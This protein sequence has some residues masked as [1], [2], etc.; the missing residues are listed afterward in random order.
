MPGQMVLSL[1]VFYV[2][3]LVMLCLTETNTCIVVFQF[4]NTMGCPLKKFLIYAD[5]SITD[6]IICVTLQ[7][8]K[9]RTTSREDSVWR[10]RRRWNGI[11]FTLKIDVNA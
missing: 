11:K 7:V 9:L 10:S 6:T 8:L 2:K 4:Y 3:F 1:T 5:L